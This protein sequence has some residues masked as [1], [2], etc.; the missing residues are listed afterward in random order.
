[1]TGSEYMVIS[2]DS[3]NNTYVSAFTGGSVVIRGGNNSSTAQITV[4]TTTTSVTGSLSATG[5]ITSNSDE[6]YKAN[7][8]SVT[9]NFVQKLSLV[10]SG[11]YDR[12]DIEATQAGV[13]AQSLQEVIPEAV[14]E[15]EEKKLTVAYGNAA[16][17]ACVELAKEIVNLKNEIAELKS[18]LEK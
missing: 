16:L 15:S 4:S 10:R 1:M 14:T 13:S 2:G 3:D 7:W 9:P 5:T 6:R 18:K 8:R 17:V 12:T 11:I